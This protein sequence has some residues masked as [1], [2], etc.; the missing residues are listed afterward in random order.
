MKIID[1]N[2][3]EI[4]VTDLPIA[5]LQADDYRHYRVTNPTEMH[6]R[7][8]KYWEDLYQKL[9]SIQRENSV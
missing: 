6:I 1:L 3:K 5:L 2:G 8:Q 4:E 9:L 7:L